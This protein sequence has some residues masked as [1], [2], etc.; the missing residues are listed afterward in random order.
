V[1]NH[2]KKWLDFTQAAVL[3]FAATHDEPFAFGQLLLFL[4]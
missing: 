4:E 3:S 1:G 2:H